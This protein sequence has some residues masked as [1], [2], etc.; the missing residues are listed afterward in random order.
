MCVHFGLEAFWGRDSGIYMGLHKR[1]LLDTGLHRVLTDTGLHDVLVDTG[2]NS[3]HSVTQWLQRQIP[4]L[5]DHNTF[6]KRGERQCMKNNIPKFKQWLYRNHNGIKD[7]RNTIHYAERTKKFL[8]V[9]SLVQ[10][11][12]PWVSLL[13]YSLGLE[14]NT[15]WSERISATVIMDWLLLVSH[16][17][18]FRPL[19]VT[20][21][22]NENGDAF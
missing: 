15:L 10:I 5:N 19:S 21:L 11:V 7:S 22:S 18:S 14:H 12:L 9:F 17:Y 3:L 1:V 16:L 6:K 20:K 13:M 2:L 4:D 8:L